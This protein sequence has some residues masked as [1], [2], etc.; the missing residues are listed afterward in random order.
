MTDLSM[1]WIAQPG[2]GDAIR[3]SREAKGISQGDLA[4]AVMRISEFDEHD[5][6]RRNAVQVAL[7]ALEHGIR[8]RRPE[9]S[10]YLPAIERA[11]DI[12]LHAKGTGNGA[13]HVSPRKEPVRLVTEAREPDRPADAIGEDKPF[14]AAL[15]ALYALGLDNQGALDGVSGSEMRC[16]VRLIQLCHDIADEWKP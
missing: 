7:S 2:L 15:K 3:A 12:D 4:D 10:Q 6:R 1:N 16:A 8:G 9:R 14:E 11:L 5:R 13:A